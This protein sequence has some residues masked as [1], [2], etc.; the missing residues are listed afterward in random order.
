MKST[1]KLLALS[2][3]VGATVTATAQTVTVDPSK[4]TLGYMNWTPVST[5]LPGFGGTGSSAWGTADL[6]ATFSGT[7]LTLTPNTSI[8]RDVAQPNPYWWNANGTGANNMDASFYN[9]TTGTFVNTTLTF[10]FDVLANTLV[11]PYTS[12]AFIK[13]FAPDYSSFV[14]STVALA[15]GIQS[16]SLLTSANVGDHI[17]YGFE[18][19]GPNVEANPSTVAALYGSVIVSPVPEP[20]TLALAGL[21]GLTAL[22]LIRRRK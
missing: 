21:G 3:I 12:V 2:A 8:A 7:T 6:D 15:P 22:S 5:D 19:V 4:L 9:E 17:Q 10:T 1:I 11:N 18:T 20:A 13:D 14:Q 16:V